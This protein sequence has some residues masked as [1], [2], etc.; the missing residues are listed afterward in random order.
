[1]LVA[2]PDLSC[3]GCNDMSVEQIPSQSTHLE[4]Q[5]SGIIH[6]HI[7]HIKRLLA[8]HLCVCQLRLHHTLKHAIPR[9]ECRLPHAPTIP[10]PTIVRI[11]LRIPPH[12]IWIKVPHP[13]PSPLLRPFHRQRKIVRRAVPVH[14]VLPVRTVALREPPRV[15]RAPFVPL[16]NWPSRGRWR[17]EEGADV[18]EEHE[19]LDVVDNE[20]GV[21]DVDAACS[22]FLLA[23]RH[24]RG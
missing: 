19:R 14:R 11:V 17:S 20:V 18:N 4:Q 22:G 7:A 12:S 24:T 15:G 1:M 10:P 8:H 3:N 21:D 9:H 6:H 13:H 16:D 2:S 5:N 23:V